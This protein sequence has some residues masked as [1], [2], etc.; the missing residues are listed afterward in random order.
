VS[1]DNADSHA[2]NG[3]TTVGGVFVAMSVPGLGVEGE[4]AR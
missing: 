3:G 1:R 4:G 2:A